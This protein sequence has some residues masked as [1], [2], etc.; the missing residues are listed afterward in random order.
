MNYIR[1]YQEYSRDSKNIQEHIKCLKGQALFF[2]DDERYM[3]KNRIS[4]LYTMYLELKHT[5]EYLKR[6][7]GLIER[8][9][10]SITAK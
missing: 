8:A 6:K 1:L 2:N 10:K 4:I 5:E 3:L 9:Q 7:Q